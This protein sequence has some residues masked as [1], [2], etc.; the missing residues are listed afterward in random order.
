MVRRLAHWVALAV[1]AWPLA[2]CASTPS[3]SPSPSPVA[4]T[5]LEYQPKRAQVIGS[6]LP[7]F[8]AAMAARGQPVQVKLEALDL[9]DDAAQKLLSDRYA[10]GSAPDVTSYPTAMVGAFAASGYLLDLASLVAAWP[11]W[12]DHFYPVLRERALSNGGHVFGIPRGATVIQLF[13]RR[14]VLGAD[15]VSTAQP[16]SWT[17]LI[18]RMVVLRGR[19]QR[20]PILIPAGASWGGGTFDEGFVNLMLGTSSQLYDEATGRWVVRSRGLDEVFRLYAQLVADRLLPVDALRRPNPWE[21]TKY[22]TFPDGEL[23]VTTQ[24]TWGWTF[25]WGPEGRRPIEDLQHRVAT[26]AF[27]TQDGA[28]PFVWAAESW[29][30]TS[31]ASSRQPDAAWA[32]VRWLSQGAPLAADL[33]AVGNLSPRDDIADI[34]PYHDQPQLIAEEKLIQVGRSLKPY[35]GIEHIRE[36]AARATEGIIEGTSTPAAAAAEFARLATSALGA[37]H[38][39]D[40]PPAP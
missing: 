10:A 37:A 22:Q 34:P 26:W 8:E 1:L 7:A 17:E 2:A 9:T 4:V 25:D 23:A 28:A 31:S 27:P 14:D 19:M 5:L 24:G 29:R 39:E 33:A 40:E 13:Y 30:W 18:D 11:D 6:L 20:P 38:V 35:D 16:A 36:A 21:P 32:L 3:P 12:R 15:G